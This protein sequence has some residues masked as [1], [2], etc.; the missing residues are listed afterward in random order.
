MSQ[1][2]GNDTSF[3]PTYEVDGEEST[4]INVIATSME[5]DGKVVEGYQ[6]TYENGTSKWTAA[7]HQDQFWDD[8]P[9][10]DKRWSFPRHMPRLVVCL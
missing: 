6:A 1:Y 5:I 8:H 9:R 10:V 7:V 3:K 4:P 2:S